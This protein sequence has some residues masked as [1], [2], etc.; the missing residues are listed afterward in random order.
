MSDSDSSN[1]SDSCDETSDDL[2]FDNKELISDGC[3]HY[4]RRCKFVSPCCQKI[5]TCRI[6]HDEEVTS[7]QL[8]R[9]AVEGLVC[10]SCDCK[11]PVSNKCISC[12]ISFGNYFCP[13]CCMFDD[14]DK[15]QFHCD[16]CGICRV[17]GRDNFFHCEKCGLCL[18][19]IKLNAHRCI[20]KSSQS[21]CPICM[22]DIHTSRIPAHVPKCGHLIHSKCYRMLLKSGNFR[23]PSCG[24]SMEDM[25]QYWEKLDEEIQ[26]TPMPSEYS[27]MKQWIL[28]QDCQN[29]SHVKFHVLGMKCETCGSYNTCGADGPSNSEG[30]RV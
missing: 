10:S 28:C 17:G 21:N 22:E 2:N 25:K 26:V 27:D 15:G 6:C 23:C 20:E 4:T 30:T 8:N 3:I 29:V 5:F 1:K 12:G 7:H 11:Q 19:T 9:H 18:P 16:K 13:V 24:V 14:R